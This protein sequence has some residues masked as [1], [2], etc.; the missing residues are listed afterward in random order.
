MKTVD[1]GD[2]VVLA[3]C[4]S[5]VLSFSTKITWLYFVAVEP[6][7]MLVGRGWESLHRYVAL[8]VCCSPIGRVGAG[9][10]VDI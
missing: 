1:E 2:G 10:F 8:S 4:E 3:M 9:R 6:K 7:H 5:R